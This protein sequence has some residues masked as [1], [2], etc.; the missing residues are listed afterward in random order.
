MTTQTKLNLAQ[1]VGIVTLLGTAFAGPLGLA[2]TAFWLTMLGVLVSAG[3]VFHYGR[4]LQAE[5]SRESPTGPAL[6]P[7]MPD[8]LKRARKRLLIWWGCG[9]AMALLAPFWEPP[10][11]G[12]K[13]GLRG[14]LIVSAAG[15]IVVSAIFLYLLRRLAA[16]P[17]P[18]T[19]GQ[20]TST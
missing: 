16:A 7:A 5:R 14:D 13:L 10:V 12:R 9:L 3:C 4:R 6:A 20:S 15:A 17:R 2:G 18:G 1:I 8:R 19:P 11:N